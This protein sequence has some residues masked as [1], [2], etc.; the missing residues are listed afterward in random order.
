[1]I[2]IMVIQIIIMVIQIIII[3]KHVQKYKGTFIPCAK[4]INR[5]CTLSIASEG[6]GGNISSLS[7]STKINSVLKTRCCLNS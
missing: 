4:A 6:P 1:M 7:Y 3:K 2:I 5:K